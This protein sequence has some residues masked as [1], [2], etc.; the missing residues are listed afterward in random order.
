MGTYLKTHSGG[1]SAEHIARNTGV[2]ID[3]VHAA[4][5]RLQSTGLAGMHRSGKGTVLWYPAEGG[6]FTYSEQ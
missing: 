6:R 2:H 5:V 3:M 1:C 4:L